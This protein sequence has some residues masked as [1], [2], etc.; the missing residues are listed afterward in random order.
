MGGRGINYIIPKCFMLLDN[1]ELSE[2]GRRRKKYA[3][4]CA[5]RE[6]LDR[7]K[8]ADTLWKRNK[9]WLLLG[10]LKR[11]ERELTQLSLPLR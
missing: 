10:K 11:L 7:L 2:A 4:I 9:Y 8:P 1:R 5:V 6:K 3:Q